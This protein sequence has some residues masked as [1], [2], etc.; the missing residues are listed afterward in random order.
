MDANLFQTEAAF[1]DSE[2]A[3]NRDNL[4]ISPR[5]FRR[6]A[7][8]THLWD[9]REFSAQ[10]LGDVAGKSLLDFG[11][12]MGE[13]AVY[14][15]KLGATVTAIDAS[16]VGIDITRERAAV[17]EVSDRVTAMVMDATRTTFP[18]N[19]FDRVHGLGI[20]HHVGLSEGLTEVKRILK[21][22]G[23]AVFL[24]PLGSIQVVETCKSWLHRKLVNRLDLIKVNENE[25]NLRLR[26]ILSCV[27]LFSNLQ[28]YPYRLLYRVRKLFCPKRFYP[29]LERFDYRLLKVAPFLSR[30]AGAALIHLKK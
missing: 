24:E 21:P 23:T 15:A 10:L 2:Y 16:T 19:S 11:C 1:A 13:E 27:A 9:W 6:Y 30:F 22:N 7:D 4:T 5:M 20:L 26:D 28:V 25:E 3:P 8:P 29:I 18:D 17:N 14:F 12:G